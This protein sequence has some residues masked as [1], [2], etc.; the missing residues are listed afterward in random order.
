[1]QVELDFDN[2]PVALHRV[3]YVGFAGGAEITSELLQLLLRILPLALGDVG[4]LP[5]EGHLHRLI[6]HVL[7][8]FL[9]SALL[10]YRQKVISIL[11]RP[12][13][14]N[15]APDFPHPATRQAVGLTALGACGRKDATP[16]PKPAS[17]WRKRH[18][19]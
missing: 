18:G 3:G 19:G 14:L 11:P 4:G 8:A 6:P 9:L 15:S 7:G 16:A 12:G 17:V 2:L 13:P 10:P 1:V 5:G